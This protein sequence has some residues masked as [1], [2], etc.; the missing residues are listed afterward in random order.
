ME[1][2][3]LHKDEGIFIVLKNSILN[4]YPYGDCCSSNWFEELD[5]E[6]FEKFLGQEF[7]SI[8]YEL[9]YE[10]PIQDTHPDECEERYIAT[11]KFTEGEFNF[12]F[13]HSCN[14]YYGGGIEKRFLTANEYQYE[15]FKINSE[16]ERQ[17]LF[18]ERQEAISNR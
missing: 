6:R 4:I 8:N 13:R 12:V 2:F 3:V 11:I 1:S 16:K 5:E 18:R 7:V 9:D 10:N 14:G 15:L 17:E